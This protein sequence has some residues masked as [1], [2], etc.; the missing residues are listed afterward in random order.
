MFKDGD[1]VV[2]RSVTKEMRADGLRAGQLGTVRNLEGKLGVEF[3]GHSDTGYN[4]GL[5]VIKF[6]ARADDGSIVPILTLC[7]VYVSDE[8]KD[9]QYRHLSDQAAE[10]HRDFREALDKLRGM[11]DDF[12]DDSQ[13]RFM[14][15][16]REVTALRD[17]LWYVQNK[18]FE[19]DKEA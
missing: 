16:M 14:L 4:A 15:Q 3:D 2:L 9:M 18:L 5:H 8:L 17:Q 10:L 11:A 12:S 6:N 7:E 13:Q 1:R 19:M